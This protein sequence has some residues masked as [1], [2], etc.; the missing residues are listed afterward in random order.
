M[1]KLNNRVIIGVAIILIVAIVY[2]F[3]EVKVYE[4][5]VQLAEVIM[6]IKD[7]PENTVITEE[8]LGIGTMYAGDIAKVKDDIVGDLGEVLGMRTRVPLYTGE[9]IRKAR[10]LNNELHMEL[11]D[12]REETLFAFEL[13]DNADKTLSLDRASFVDIWASPTTRGIGEGLES[14]T[15]LREKA[16]ADISKGSKEDGTVAFIHIRLTDQE[17]K[18]VLDID[19]GD[20]HL[21]Y[22][23]YTDDRFYEM[24]GKMIDG[25]IFGGR[26][27]EELGSL[28]EDE[29]ENTNLGDRIDEVM[30]FDIDGNTGEGEDE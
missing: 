24:T 28:E 19:K 27:E 29:A 18:E 20:F 9:T 5:G 3:Q 14:Y 23:L 17:I 30:D 2:Y 1:K 8:M 25:N 21:R 26:Q 16:V 11:A 13:E 6:P 4:V 22:T 10:L 15:V 12:N 7:I